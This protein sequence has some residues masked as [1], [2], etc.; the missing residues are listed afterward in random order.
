VV[1][2]DARLEFISVSRDHLTKLTFLGRFVPRSG[3]T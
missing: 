1:S 3:V 2:A